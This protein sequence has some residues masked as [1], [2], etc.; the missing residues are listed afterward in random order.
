[1]PG[2]HAF[3]KSVRGPVHAQ[4]SARGTRKPFG[5]PAATSARA[6]GC[7]RLRAGAQQHARPA[8]AAFE[9]V[10]PLSTDLYALTGRGRW[11]TRGSTAAWRR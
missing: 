6:L 7:S 1:M 11:R 5:E 8:F 9:H 3:S 4:E 2:A 10:E